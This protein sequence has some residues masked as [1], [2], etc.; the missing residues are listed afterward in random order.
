M[1]P[2]LFFRNL[3]NSHVP[4]L[5]QRGVEEDMNTV[6]VSTWVLHTGGHSRELVT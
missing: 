1:S 2:C 4:I 6:E 3:H 5:G